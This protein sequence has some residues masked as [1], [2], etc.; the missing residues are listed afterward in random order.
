MEVGWCLH[1]IDPSNDELLEVWIDFSKR[2]DK[3]KE[4]ECNKKWETFK[5]E[6]L[7]IGSL[8][9]WAKKDNFEKYNEIY[10]LIITK[11]NS[12]NNSKA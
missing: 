10:N 7:D 9:Y 1:N 5:C 6:G 2:S 3:F 12:N 11:I 8:Y 4:G